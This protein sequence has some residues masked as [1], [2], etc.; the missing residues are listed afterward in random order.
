[1]EDGGLPDPLLPSAPGPGA[2]WGEGR[3]RYCC[4]D[5]RAAL[6]GRP[7][8]LTRFEELLHVSQRYAVIREEQARDFTLGWPALRACVRRLG[9]HMVAT[10]VLEEADDVFFCNHDEVGATLRAGER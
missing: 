6:V 2:V 7:R 3:Y 10:G 4:A 5:C 9:A 8:L 1:M